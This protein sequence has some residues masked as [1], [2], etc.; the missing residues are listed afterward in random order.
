ME[1]QMYFPGERK[2]EA[3]GDR[4]NMFEDFEGSSAFDIELLAGPASLEVFG[5]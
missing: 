3:M 4:A 1:N 5:L 2:S